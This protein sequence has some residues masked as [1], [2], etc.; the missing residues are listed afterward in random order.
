MYETTTRFV[1]DLHA[2]GRVAELGFAPWRMAQ[3]EGSTENTEDKRRQTDFREVV[4]LSFSF[5]CLQVRSPDWPE[6]E[7]RWAP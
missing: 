2:A 1:M 7:L 6:A 3:L 5:R 4:N